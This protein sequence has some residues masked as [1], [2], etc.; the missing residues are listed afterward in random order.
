M[1][2]TERGDVAFIAASK[3]AY[4]FRAYTFITSISSRRQPI[5]I[6]VMKNNYKLKCPPF[7][8]ALL[9]RGTV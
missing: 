1:A 4:L 5:N 9:P 7:R 8:K 2:G 3:Y 6:S